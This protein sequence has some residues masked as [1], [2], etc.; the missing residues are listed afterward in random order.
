MK[1]YSG[2]DL[3]RDTPTRNAL[4]YLWDA[5]HELDNR[6]VSVES[7]TSAEFDAI[8]TALQRG[9]TY[10]MN[11]SGLGGKLLER[12]LS[13]ASYCAMFACTIDLG[14][15]G[16]YE[17][18]TEVLNT[19]PHI[20]KRAASNAKIKMQLE[21]LYLVLAHINPLTNVG[22]NARAYLYHNTDVVGFA[23]TATGVATDQVQHCFGHIIDAKP[24]DYVKVTQSL[25]AR[26]G[27]TQGRTTL[28]L[29]RLK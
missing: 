10:E 29:L 8:R 4:R 5:F 11:V 1:P 27:N 15:S 7:I 12:Q 13:L 3:V 9:G 28:L 26:K 18:D 14:G 21:G 24:G 25:G 17:W 22:G 23:Y 16:D 20:F 19:A 6:E 2:V